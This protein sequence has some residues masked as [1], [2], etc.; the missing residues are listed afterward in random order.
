MTPMLLHKK[1]RALIL[2]P[3]YPEQLTAIIPTAK[4]FLFRGESFVAVPHRIEETKVLRN[5]NFQAP[6]PIRYAYKWS[7]GKEPFAAQ[8]DTA[9]FLTLYNRA[10][11]LNDMGTGKTLSTLWAYDFLHDEGVADKMLVVCPLSTMERTWGDEVFINFPHL[12]AVVLYGSRDKRLKLLGQ[13]ADIYIINHDGLEI[14]A[15]ELKN[16]PD[17]NVVVVDEI[18]QAGRNAQTD[19]WK[20]LNLVVNKQHPRIAWG[21]TGTPTPNEPTDAWAQCR[22]IAP[23]KVP[24][25]YNRFKDSVMRQVS[26]YK[27]IA[28]DSALDTVR[29]AM[30][31]AI[32]FAREDCVDLPDCMEETRTVELSP[33]QKKAYKDM[34]THLHAEM[35]AGQITAVN[36]A[37][38]LA[39]LV[40]IACGVAYS[41][42]GKEVTL[43]AGNRLETVFEIIEEA[44][45]K[46]IVFVPFIGAL[47]AVAYELLYKLD[48][49][50]YTEAKLS[51]SITGPVEI[52]HGGV[53]KNE[54]DRIFSAFQNETSPRVIVA[55]PAAMSHGLTLTAANTIV[56]YAPIT[57]NETYEQAN[58]RV[59]RPGQKLKQ[60]IVNV[61]GSPVER[62][63]YARLQKRQKTQG[64]LL[65]MIKNS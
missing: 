16:R 11:C 15:S 10:F 23:E 31:P 64:L 17:I 1:Q 36:E 45:A 3:E 63:L 13:E 25:Y 12:N 7:G 55:Q 61:E 29:N 5:M 41:P 22:L 14:I 39:K 54:R 60:L 35:A 46:V 51:G 37:V 21:L 65:D 59:S 34:M 28:R 2:R 27:W 20:A 32:R 4:T 57:S 62:L 49:A 48:K 18:A 9:E 56:W 43:P 38:K 53:S 52:I 33:E 26:T 8:I 6:S 30:Q 24:P 47:N 19:R 40:Q 44:P 58:A 50:A 42:D